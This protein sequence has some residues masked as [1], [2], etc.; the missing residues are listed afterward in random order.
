MSVEH[1]IWGHCKKCN[2]RIPRSERTCIYC[3]EENAT[4]EQ[5][6]DEKTEFY[7]KGFG[8]L[9]G[10]MLAFIV[11]VVLLIVVVRIMYVLIEG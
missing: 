8:L 6:L 7:T 1:I 11:G 9:F 5:S 3:G 10:L 4:P 2:K